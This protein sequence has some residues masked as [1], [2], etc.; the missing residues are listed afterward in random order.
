MSTSQTRRVVITGMGLISPLGNDRNALWEGIKAGRSGVRPL[1]CLPAVHLLDAD[2]YSVVRCTDRTTNRHA[3]QMVDIPNGN[4]ANT[5][6]NA[7]WPAH[8]AAEYRRAAEYPL[9]QQRI[10]CMKSR[11][12][13]KPPGPVSSPCTVADHDILLQSTLHRRLA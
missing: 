3:S 1:Q 8:R 9:V 6:H 11:P 13:V 10:A 2:H 12:P 7:A 4:I 5:Q